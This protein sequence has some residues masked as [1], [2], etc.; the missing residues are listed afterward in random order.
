MTGPTTA[1]T[2]SEADFQA[3]VIHLA[4]MS[5]WLVHH[6]RPAIDRSGKWTTPITG[7]AGFPDLVLAHPE[8]GVLLLE[9]K[10]ETGQPTDRQRAWLRALRDGGAEAWLARP[11]DLLWIA[12]RLR[13]ERHD[14]RDP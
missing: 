11:G 4:R 10:S 6:T 7:D 1:P 2:I 3:Q 13:G 5:G 14:R 8:R 9:L 12:A